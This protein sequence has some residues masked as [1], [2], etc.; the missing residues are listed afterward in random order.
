MMNDINAKPYMN[1]YLAGFLLGLTLLASFAVLGTG[2]G[3]S[4][5]LARLSAWCGLCVA[6][7]HF[8]ASKYF[9]AWG[10]KPLQHYIFFMMIGVAIGGFCS[11]LVMNRIGIE[12]ERGRSFKAGSR[13]WLALSGGVLA[14][15]AGRLARGCTSSQGLSGTALL[16]TGS[17]VFLGCVFAGG[18]LAAYF[19]RRQW[20]D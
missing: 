20:Y 15:F 18:Y 11:A 13:V 10:E 16:V 12:T 2:L 5:G 6:P 4:G 8:L 14:G 7:D 3:A 19:V 9:G 17:L 1:P